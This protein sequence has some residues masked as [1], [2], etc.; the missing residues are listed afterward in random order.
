[1]RALS[2]LTPRM[3]AYCVRALRARLTTWRGTATDGQDG[4]RR[5]G[6]GMW[7]RW[8]SLGEEEAVVGLGDRR[9]GER[10]MGEEERRRWSSERRDGRKGRKK[11]IER[12][13]L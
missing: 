1:M 13:W 6:E 8:A 10:R 5:R 12:K 11:G 4:V 7:F 3:Q 2:R 9:E